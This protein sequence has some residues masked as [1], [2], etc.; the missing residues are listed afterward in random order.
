MRSRSRAVQLPFADG[1][2]GGEL[3]LALL[4]KARRADAAGIAELEIQVGPCVR[5]VSVAPRAVP[6]QRPTSALDR[7]TLVATETRYTCRDRYELHDTPAGDPHDAKSP[8]GDSEIVA[9]PECTHDPIEHVVTRYRFEVDHRFVTPDWDMLARWTGVPLRAGAP[10]CGLPPKNE[11]R[12]KL[13][14]KTDAPALAAVPAPAATPAAIIA[15][16]KDAERTARDGH[17]DDAARLATEALAALDDRMLDG[18]DGKARDEL[19]YWIAAA[20]FYQI[21][22]DVAAF[23][24]RAAPA[25]ATP[26]WAAEL[27]GAI[28]RIAA[29]YTALR[30][31]V[32][33]PAVEHWLRAGAQ[34]L[35]TVHAHA[36]ELLDRVGQSNA[37]EAERAKARAL[38][39]AAHGAR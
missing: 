19:V 25:T 18:L 9:V 22:P 28:D 23:L 33:V 16:A 26:A 13:V 21:E 34:R 10:R 32:R 8:A 5:E 3:V 36:A 35:S 38:L 29:R 20:H 2:H 4:A 7:I 14:A 1:Q 11:L 30:D 31:L 6:A 15:L 17:A 37:A 24:A 12:A 39:D 27:G